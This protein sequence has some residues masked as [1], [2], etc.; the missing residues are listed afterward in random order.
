[1]NEESS[2]SNKTLVDPLGNP[3]GKPKKATVRIP[4]TTIATWLTFFYVF[5]IRSDELVSVANRWIFGPGDL[6][7]VEFEHIARVD[8][9]RLSDSHDQPRTSIDSDTTSVA[10]EFKV[11]N[12]SQQTI[13]VQRVE[14]ELEARGTIPEG[15]VKKTSALQV[16]GEYTLILPNLQPDEQA[17]RYVNVPHVLKPG[18]ADAFTVILVRPL[19]VDITGTIYITPRLITSAG[20][21]QLESFDIPLLSDR[22]RISVGAVWQGSPIAPEVESRPESRL[23]PSASP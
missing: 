9:S 22:R 3:L 15:T 5:I 10:L 12:N 1:M 23:A 13:L 14:I 21:T 2:S 6:S 20:I 4:W 11:V 18:D 17:V 7:V 16:S 8:Q 19:H